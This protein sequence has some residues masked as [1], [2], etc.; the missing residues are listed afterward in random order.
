MCPP[1]LVCAWLT[2]RELTNVRLEGMLPVPP[3]F[4][5]K[6]FGAQSK[7]EHA[8]VPREL[9]AQ[10]RWSPGL[11]FPTC[12]ASLPAPL[13]QARG[14]G[15]VCR[16]QS[17]GPI[18]TLELRQRS[19]PTLAPRWRHGWGRVQDPVWGG[20]GPA[21]LQMAPLG[22]VGPHSK[23]EED[24]EAGV[25]S[26]AGRAT[27]GQ[28]AA[29][30]DNPEDPGPEQWDGAQPAGVGDNPTCRRGDTEAHA[31]LMGTSWGP[32]VPEPS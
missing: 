28:A 30:P 32:S 8:E 1:V 17:P 21:Q 25:A 12:Q 9:G 10:L 2:P 22:Q 27:Q 11:H 26:Q 24:Q 20:F 31:P 4:G 14:C 16:G 29:V 15:L 18:P 3:H 5:G 13:Y 7:D 23:V 19:D 6:E